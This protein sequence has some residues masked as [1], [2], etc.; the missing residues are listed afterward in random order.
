MA[1][2]AKNPCGTI[3]MVVDQDCQLMGSINIFVNYLTATKQRL[4]SY[5]PLE[6][7]GKMEQYMNWHLTVLK[8]CIARLVKVLVGPKAFGQEHYSGEEVEAA[9]EALFG[10]VLKRINAM[11]ENS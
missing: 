3:P 1:Y 10:D 11:L 2:L 8:P 9:K 7:S 4:Q 5:N 6:Y